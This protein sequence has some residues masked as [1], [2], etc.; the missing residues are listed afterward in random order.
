MDPRD[1]VAQAELLAR[2]GTTVAH[3]SALS[4]AYYGA[5]NVATELL[6]ALHFRI[7]R[8]HTGMVAPRAGPF[9]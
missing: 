8:G 2:M 4:R 5:Y 1:F 3:R 6:A 7:P 9:R